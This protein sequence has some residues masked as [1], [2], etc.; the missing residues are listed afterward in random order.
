MNDR[1]SQPHPPPG[2]A[3]CGT[4]ACA[5]TLHSLHALLG[6]DVYNHHVDEL[7]DII[8]LMVDL[9][10]GCIHFA[11]L[12]CHPEPGCAH[13]LVAIPWGQLTLDTALRC[14]RLDASLQH[15]AVA[16][17]FTGSGRAVR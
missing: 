9:R 12:R 7:G 14:F 15:L 4:G 2:A 11:L 16:P 5:P 8:D 1:I 10:T 3:P 13:K 6:S 17:A